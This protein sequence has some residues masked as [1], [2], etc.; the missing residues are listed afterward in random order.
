MIFHTTAIADAGL[1]L[2]C[3]NAPRTRK[4]SIA[5]TPI[6]ST[7]HL[8]WLAAVLE[9]PDRELAIAVVREDLAG[10]APL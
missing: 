8:A 6:Q 5:S 7:S 2:A 9:D 3:R 4:T 10:T 1:L